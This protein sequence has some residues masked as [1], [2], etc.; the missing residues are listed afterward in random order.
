MTIFDVAI[1][2]LG[3]GVDVPDKTGFQE[4]NG[5]AEVIQL[6]LVTFFLGSQ[7][8]LEA[9]SAWLQGDDKSIDDG[10]VGVGVKSVSG[11]GTTDRLRGHSSEGEK[12]V[13][14]CRVFSAEL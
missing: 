4:L 1:R 10:L 12:M 2:G 7:L 6:L 3:E 9:V 14:G 11:D 13:G 8:L 5:F